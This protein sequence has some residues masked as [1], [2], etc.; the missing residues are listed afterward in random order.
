MPKCKW[1]KEEVA[2]EEAMVIEKETGQLLKSGKPKV[3]RSYYHEDCMDKYLE[4]KEKKLIEQE[5]LDALVKTIIAIHS[6]R[7]EDFPQRFYVD[8]Q[9]IRNGYRRGD[10]KQVKSKSGTPYYV[11]E[12]AY[13]YV[14]SNIEY[15]KLQKSF[16][17]IYGEMRYGLAIMRDKL[18]MI[19]QRELE[20]I[21]AKRAAKKQLKEKVFRDDRANYKNKKYENDIS[22]F[23]D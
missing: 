5:Q 13:E 7:P 9:D 10:R 6:I 11:I 21:R 4:D 17:S 3:L 12:S 20:R 14:R 23:L 15:A 19:R 22:D 1:C 8:I 2:K 18:P 16:D